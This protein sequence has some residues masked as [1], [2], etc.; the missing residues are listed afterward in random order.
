MGTE[1]LIPPIEPQGANE[2]EHLQQV[3]PQ[4]RNQPSSLTSP[5]AD[6]PGA[7]SSL[8]HVH[9]SHFTNLHVGSRY[10]FPMELLSLQAL[11]AAQRNDRLAGE[12]SRVA[13][14]LGAEK[15][16]ADQKHKTIPHIEVGPVELYANLYMIWIVIMQLS[17]FPVIMHLA[18]LI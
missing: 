15:D 18:L 14:Q 13:H 17:P 9:K 16:S 2:T 11:D 8:P 3:P 1:T 10:S 7:A 5:D 6:T 4:G 12:Y